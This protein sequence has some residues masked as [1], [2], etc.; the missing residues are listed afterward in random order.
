MKM[1]KIRFIILGVWSI[2]CKIISIILE[3][4]GNFKGED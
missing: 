2:I 4:I 3:I 1:L